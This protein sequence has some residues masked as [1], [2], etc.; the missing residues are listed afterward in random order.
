MGTFTQLSGLCQRWWRVFDRYAVLN[1][2]GA[3][4]SALLLLLGS[5]YAVGYETQPQAQAQSIEVGFSPE[6]SAERLV[7]KTID[8]A[9]R[10]I[11]L[12]AYSFTSPEVGRGLINAKSRGVDVAVVADAK[13]NISEGGKGTHALSALVTAGIPVRVVSVYPIHHDKFIVTDGSNV[14]T[15]S[16]NYS[17]AAAERNSENAL[18][19]R[20]NPDIAARY[21]AHWQDRWAKGQDFN[22]R[23]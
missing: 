8:T 5:G 14:Q 1:A 22:P 10:S 19:I 7:E 15:G 13:A 12:A 4:A 9:Q 17:R 3:S 16:F 18:L 23:Y 20:N 6:G 21:L 2:F 11:R